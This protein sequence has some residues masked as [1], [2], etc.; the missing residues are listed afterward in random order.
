MRGYPRLK[1]DPQSR[2][3]VFKNIS[4]TIFIIT[5]SKNRLKETYTR[6]LKQKYLLKMAFEIINVCECLCARSL[7]A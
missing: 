1:D 3:C 7:R 6:Y 4:A 2:R 5:N